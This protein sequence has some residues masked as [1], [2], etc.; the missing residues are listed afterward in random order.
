MSFSC[1]SFVYRFLGLICRIFSFSCRI[2]RLHDWGYGIIILSFYY[3]EASGEVLLFVLFIFVSND[4]GVVTQVRRDIST[5][6]PMDPEFSFAFV[7]CY[8]GLGAAEWRDVSRSVDG[9]LEFRTRCDSSDCVENTI[10][11]FRITN[12]IL[13]K[14]LILV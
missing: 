3:R 2:F 11:L 5:F 14:N 6:V 4:C 13:K 12:E 10:S 1:L 9:V 7:I 8:C